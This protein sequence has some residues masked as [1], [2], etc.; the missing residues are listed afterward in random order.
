MYHLC[1]C[2]SSE[3]QTICWQAFIAVASLSPACACQRDLGPG[4]CHSTKI[5]TN[6]AHLRLREKESNFG[7]ILMK[8]EDLVET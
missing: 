8:D 1:F 3:T 7:R 2:I 6:K 5:H 4:F